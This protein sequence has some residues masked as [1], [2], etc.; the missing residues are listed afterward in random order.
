MLNEC[1]AVMVLNDGCI[2]TSLGE[3]SYDPMHRDSDLICL[4]WAPGISI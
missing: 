3:D 2:V 1:L 4:G